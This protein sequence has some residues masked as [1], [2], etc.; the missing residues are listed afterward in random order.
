M[1]RTARWWLAGAVVLVLGAGLL[2]ASIGGSGSPQAATVSSGEAGRG[3]HVAALTLNSLE[4]KRI[5]VPS[6]RPGAL[7]FTVSSCVSCLVSARALGELKAGLGDR[8]DVVWVGIDPSDPPDAVRARRKSLGD[9]VYPFAID[10]GGTRLIEP[11]KEQ[12]A[13]AFK[14]AGAS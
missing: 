8:A 13:S 11:N 6:G 10:G 3:A 4:G 14:Q 2:A 1:S 7:F 9:P 12:L 5:N